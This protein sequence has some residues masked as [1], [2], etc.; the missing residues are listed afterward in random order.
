MID[1]RSLIALTATAPFMVKAPRLDM[2]D[3]RL[4]ALELEDGEDVKILSISPDATTIVGIKDRERLCFYRS[5]SPFY[6]TAVIDVLSTSDP[7]PE[8]QAIDP[9]SIRWSPD[10]SRI[11]FSINAFLYMRDSDIYVV[12]SAT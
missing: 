1:R 12:E 3:L 11:A 7:L 10:S 4:D 9:S 8:L 6:E 2:P 5:E